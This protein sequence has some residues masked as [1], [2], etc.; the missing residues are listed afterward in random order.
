MWRLVR[1]VKREMSRMAAAECFLHGDAM[2]TPDKIARD[3]HKEASTGGLA[4]HITRGLAKG[5][6]GPVELPKGFGPKG[7]KLTKG[8]RRKP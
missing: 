4:P 2:T 8:K 5:M 1:Q 3:A 6:V 7:E